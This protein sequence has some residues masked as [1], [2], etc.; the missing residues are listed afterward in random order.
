MTFT[1]ISAHDIDYDVRIERVFRLNFP[2][3]WDGI[4]AWKLDTKILLP[5][6]AK[7]IFILYHTGTTH[8]FECRR[9]YSTL[10]HTQIYIYVYPHMQSLKISYFFLSYTRPMYRHTQECARIVD[11]SLKATVISLSHKLL[12]RNCIIINSKGTQSAKW[13][14]GRHCGQPPSHPAM[15]RDS[16]GSRKQAGKKTASQSRLIF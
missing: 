15:A 16:K 8:S 14:A 2:L 6:S 1:S 9:V 4:E 10:S 3:S 7:L 11:I 5:S 13:I 12:A